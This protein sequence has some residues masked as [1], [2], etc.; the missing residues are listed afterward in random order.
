MVQKTKKKKKKK[1]QK[2]FAL[3]VATDDEIN[4]VCVVA[5]ERGEVGGGR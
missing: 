2:K 3:R 5:G 1:E 4:G